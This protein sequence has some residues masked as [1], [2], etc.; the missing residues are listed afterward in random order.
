[1]ASNTAWVRKSRLS[2]SSRRAN[3]MEA[4]APIGAAVIGVA[5]A[6]DLAATRLGLYCLCGVHRVLVTQTLDDLVCRDPAI[7]VEGNQKA[8]GRLKPLQAIHA[9]GCIGR[10]DPAGYAE[11]RTEQRQQQL[12]T[13]D[14][15][16]LNPALIRERPG[17]YIYR[18]KMSPASLAERQEFESVCC[19]MQKNTRPKR[20]GDKERRHPEHPRCRVAPT[21]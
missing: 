2:K 1:M 13:P 5:P 20:A 4:I 15:V 21:S 19:R 3:G 17:P 12:E 14:R 18:N 8:Y 11:Y 10:P 7:V 16:E 6:A 9:A